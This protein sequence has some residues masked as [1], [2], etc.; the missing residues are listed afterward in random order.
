MSPRCWPAMTDD[1]G[2]RRGREKRPC[3]RPRRAFKENARAALG[4]R[5]CSGRS[6]R[7]ARASST[8]AAARRRAA[9][10]RGA[11]RRRPRH[12][13]PYAR[14]SRPLSRAL[15][16][17]SRQPA[18][19]CIGRAT[20]RGARASSSRSAAGLA[21]ETVTKGKSM[22]GEEIA[23]NE[24]WS[25]RHRAGRDRSRR[26]H[27][28]APR[29][30]PSHIIAPAFTS[31]RTRSRPTSA[32]AH[33]R[34]ADPTATLDEPRRCSPKR[35]R[36]LREKFLAA[37]VGITGANFLIAETGT[38][39][40]VTNEGNGD[41]TQTLP[42]VAYRARQPSKSSCRRLEDA[43]TILR[44]LARSATGQEF[45]VYTTFSTGPRRNADPDGPE[46]FHVVLLDNGRSGDARN[47]VPGHAALHPLR[48]LPQSLPGLSGG[49]R[50][51]LW[52][53][54]SRPDGR[55]ADAGA[56][57]HR[58]GRPP[59]QRLDLLRALRG[60]LP[61]ED[62]AAEDDAALA[63]AGIRAAPAAGARPQG[64]R[65]WAFLAQPAGASTGLWRVLPW[66][67]RTAA[68]EAAFHSVPLA[69]GWTRFR[70][71]P[72]P[73]G[74]PS[75]IVGASGAGMADLATARCCCRASARVSG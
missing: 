6:K 18:A 43:S 2:D 13:G 9:G 57:R 36:M 64:L 38:S 30:T 33:T 52:L 56:H 15:R 73:E 59:A 28:P 8:A 51:C 24:H 7:A 34:P 1:A 37:D 26:I 60:G 61:D 22:V 69:G 72:A 5:S 54:L 39:I 3:R 67:A 44:L 66:R 74:R 53:G 23:L 20:R 71:L 45:P 40:I 62:P 4:T 42:R 14:A 47:R 65:L 70:D 27:H 49:R 17:Q 41:L 12:Q 31:P 46:Q 11:A 35:A 21:R 68:A 50:P 16:A 63:R 75:W 19:T 58:G 25:E 29:R 55:G 10:I 48:R 32:R